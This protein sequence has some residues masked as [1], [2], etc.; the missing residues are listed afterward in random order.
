MKNWGSG[1][2]LSHRGRRL[3]NGEDVVCGDVDGFSLTGV[4][5]EDTGGCVIA[6]ASGE[7]VLVAGSSV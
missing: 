4:F 7:G 6:A 5:V 2:F 3:V 1:R